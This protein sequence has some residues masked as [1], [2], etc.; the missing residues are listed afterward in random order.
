MSKVLIRKG[1]YATLPDDSYLNRKALNKS[2]LLC[3]PI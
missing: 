1:K 2:E 3:L